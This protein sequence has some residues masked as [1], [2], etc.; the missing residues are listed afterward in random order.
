[1]ANLLDAALR[2]RETYGFS[3]IP[4]DGPTKKSLIPWNEFKTRKP[5]AE[6]IRQWW[7][8]WPNAGISAVAG[9]S[10]IIIVD[11]DKPEIAAPWL[12]EHIPD[13]HHGPVASTPHGGQ[14]IY[15]LQNENKYP[16]CVKFPGGD[17]LSGDHLV[18]L[19]PTAGNN[20]V[21]YK[22]IVKLADAP[23]PPLTP[24]LA[25]YLKDV[26]ICISSSVTDSV[27]SC[28]KKQLFQSGS[29]NDDLFHVVN[30]LGRG[31]EDQ[32]TAWQVLEILANN[33]NPPLTDTRELKA[34]FESAF[35]REDL[36]KRNLT[37]EVLDWVSVTSGDFSVTEACQAVTACDKNQRATVRKILQRLKDERVIEKFGAKDGHFRRIERDMEAIDI[38]IEDDTTL[39]VKWPFEIERLVNTLP[40]TIVIIAG[41]PDAG[42]TA[43]LLN[44]AVLNRDAKKV[45]YLSSEMGRAEL[46]SRCKKFDILL[47]EWKKIAFY[48]RANNFHDGIDPNGINIIDY[49][50]ISTDLFMV[51]DYIKKIYDTLD[52]GIAIIALQKKKGA[53]LGRGAEFSLEKAR[54]YLSMDRD[55]VGNIIKI[56]KAKNWANEESNPVGMVRRFK[57]VKG[58]NFKSETEGWQR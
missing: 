24:N 30:S 12:E 31:G 46:R 20:G 27:T 40:K 51:A 33:C 35:K 15:F 50:E 48:N 9:P 28:D 49:L 4:I 6:E 10:G 37:Q 18:N 38:T 29:R 55:D 53:D 2:Y 11:V 5:S 1:M 21:C 3:V 58:C 39:P 26:N 8:K 7:K 17:I 52:Q 13:S 34:L 32:N 45:R 47:A 22:W 19:P 41:A 16:A 25:R 14:H 56:V 54:L 43:F 44:V 42:K 36:R 23:I 57:L